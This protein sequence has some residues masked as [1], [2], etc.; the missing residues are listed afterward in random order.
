MKT[1]G[2]R[3]EITNEFLLGILD[4]KGGA[5]HNV[6][7]D[8]EYFKPDRFYIILE[9]PDLPEIESGMMAMTIVPTMQSTYGEDGSL[10]KVERIDPPK[11]Q[12]DEGTEKPATG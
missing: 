8:Q 6:Y 9:H 2:A 3:I 11:L 12:P 4:F 5:I 7:Q 10:I 1:H